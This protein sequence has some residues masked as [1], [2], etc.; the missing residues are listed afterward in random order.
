VL[1]GNVTNQTFNLG[2]AKSI[3]L[4]SITHQSIAPTCNFGNPNIGSNFGFNVAWHWQS[5]FDWYGTFNG[6]ARA[7]YHSYSLFDAQINK[8]LP[9]NTHH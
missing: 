3:I 4:P 8:K 7:V 2:A 5:Q 6:K 1:G 9:A